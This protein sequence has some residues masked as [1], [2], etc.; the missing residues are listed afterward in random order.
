MIAFKTL[1]DGRFIAGDRATG[2]T[3]EAD[4]GSR[5]A[6]ESALEP[7]MTAERMIQAQVAIRATPLKHLSCCCCG[8]NT[9]G[10][11]WYNRDTGYGL[12]ADCVDFVNKP[13]SAEAMRSNYGDR[14]IHYDASPEAIALVDLARWR[15]LPDLEPTAPEGETP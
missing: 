6:I 15:L 4:P 13:P 11:Q 1:D 14:G 7:L 3:A 5:R 10:R 9:K 8:N 2:V 12:C